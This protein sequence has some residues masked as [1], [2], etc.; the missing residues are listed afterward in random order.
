MLK[1]MK[2]SSQKRL[3]NNYFKQDESIIKRI[4]KQMEKNNT[5]GFQKNWHTKTNAQIIRKQNKGQKL[6]DMTAIQELSNFGTLAGCNIKQINSKLE[7]F[8]FSLFFFF[9]INI[10]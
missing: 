3:P 1:Q 5:M 8:G 2:I 7:A 10:W 9:S 4:T 6:T